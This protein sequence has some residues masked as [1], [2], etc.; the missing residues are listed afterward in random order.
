M[1]EPTPTQDPSLSRRLADFG[2]LQEAI[3]YAAEGARGLN[4]Y[5]PRGELE[6]TVT[7]AEI[8]DK[9]QEVGRRFIQFGV[10]KGSR[11]ALIA[12][13]S[14]EFVCYFLGC[15]Y[16]G[17]L[18]VPLP[19]PTSFGGREGYTS[20]LNQQMSSC[21]AIVAISASYMLP[22]LDEATSN[23]KM[24]FVGTSTT[25]E[26]QAS[27]KDLKNV[28]LPTSK[29]EDL[30]YL[31]YSSGSTRF[32]HG[33][34]VTHRSLMANCR[35][36]G[37]EGM[38]L[39][40][41][42]R[43]ISWLPFYHDMGL[44]GTLL[45]P[46]ANQVSTDYL[47]T[48]AFARRPLQWLKLISKN[49][50]TLAYSPTFGYDICAR[51]ASPNKIAD[52][53]LSSWRIAGIGGDMIRA[54][55]LTNFQETFAHVGF[56]S[57]TFVPSYGLAECTLAVSFARKNTGFEIDLVDER[58]LSGEENCLKEFKVNGNGAN[59]RGVVNCGIPINEYE[60]EIRDDDNNDLGEYKI[61]RV[62]VRGES[63]MVGYFQDQEA[64]DAC[65]S[66]D[67]WLD[68][69]D[70]GYMKEGSLYIIG[71]IKDLIIINGKNH[72]P[73]D[74]EW[75]VE[76]LGDLRSGDTAA[77]SIPGERDEEIPAIL[78]QCRTRDEEERLAMENTIKDKVHSLI[79]ISPVVALIP[80]RS[81]PRTS[82]GKLSRVKAR[83]QYL[84]G[85]LMI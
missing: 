65:L 6:N 74:I 46:I 31:Q 13:T 5:S 75:A 30:A 59:Y 7:F 61:G 58:V 57:T 3:E 9:A 67:G 83:K 26:A 29:P 81:L 24:K 21:G 49:K 32:P 34:A 60:L 62:C 68:T 25:F 38:D 72:W 55:V 12:E 66:A 23:L 36:I 17:L 19:L 54:D 27:M 53:D 64:T 33:V 79:G 2:T 15:Q 16:A 85:E 37:N 41:D 45:A 14:D 22:L 48:E 18:P 47:A 80:P 43:C 10:K 78:V 71:R 42:D 44:V 76:Q 82:S 39:N 69:G 51:R 73:Q 11:V 84:A 56:R 28:E 1:L 35:G 77:V 50:G 20:Q 40:E 70:I 52:L 4:F 63:V 8:R